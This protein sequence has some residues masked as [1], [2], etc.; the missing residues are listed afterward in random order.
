LRQFV[1]VPKLGSQQLTQIEGGVA[2]VIPL[3]LSCKLHAEMEEQDRKLLETIKNI[4]RQKIGDSE[5]SN[6]INNN[7]QELTNIEKTNT[8]DAATISRHNELVSLLVNE[9]ESQIEIGL[10]F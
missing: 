4:N 6:S 1:V 7:S 8:K 3:R 10:P 2:E 9:V 5:E